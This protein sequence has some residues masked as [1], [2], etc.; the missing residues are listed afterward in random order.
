V[1]PL[2][3][4]A[5]IDAPEGAVRRV[6]ARTDIWTR[7]ARAIGGHAEVAGEQTGDRAPLR[8]GDLIRFEPERS[9]RGWSASLMQPRSL[10]LAIAIADGLPRFDL[11]AGPANLCRIVV[12]TASTGAG[13]LVTV[14][15]QLELAPRLITP[16][17]RRRV[18]A[19]GQLLLGIVR[20]SAA[21]IHV[22]VAGVIIED[23]RV[24]AARRTHPPALAGKWELPG[25]KVGPGET[26]ADALARELAEELSIEV[27]V[28]DRFGAEVELGDNQVLRCRTARICAGRP[29]PTEHDLVHWVGST[30]LDRLDWLTA[31]REFLPLLR[32]SLDQI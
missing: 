23:G 13:T 4:T 15:T 11:L 22:V 16:L 29:D 18:L 14:D 24:L 19:A 6:L 9:R 17:Y 32:R 31:D 5:L 21:E 30:E 25:G 26:E 28:G 7:T 12:S 27:A 1:I 2:R 3:V 8:S 10:I 20:L